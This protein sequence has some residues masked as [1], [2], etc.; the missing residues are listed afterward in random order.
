[1]AAKTAMQFSGYKA[2][3]LLARSDKISRESPWAYIK[4][5]KNRRNLNNKI[6]RVR[7]KMSKMRIWENG[8]RD[9]RDIQYGRHSQSS[10]N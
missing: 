1:M 5:W 6:H 3:R 10:L 2:M 9:R 7:L 4:L 8:Y